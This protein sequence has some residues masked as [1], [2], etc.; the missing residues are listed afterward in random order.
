MYL[1]CIVF[2]SLFLLQYIKSNNSR[3]AQG[4]KYN[5]FPIKKAT[6]YQ[7]R[8]VKLNYD[9]VGRWVSLYSC[10]L[11]EMNGNLEIERDLPVS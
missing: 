6:N 1:S 5:L 3:E 2:I 10:C 8:F 9:F 11:L 7:I 4:L